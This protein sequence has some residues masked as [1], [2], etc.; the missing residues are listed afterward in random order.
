MKAISSFLRR[1]RE[2]PD[3]R[4]E[5]RRQVLTDELLD[6]PAR[7]ERLRAE[8][9]EEFR[10]V[11]EVI[12]A[13]TERMDRVE[14]QL[15]ENAR[16]IAENSRQ[17]AENSRQIASLTERMDRVEAQLQE[18]ARQIAE[19]S[20]QIASLTERM[21]RVE[22]QL[23]ENARQIAENSRQI[24][25]LTRVVR[26]HTRTLSRHGLF[27]GAAVEVQARNS[28][29]AQAEGRGLRFLRPFRFVAGPDWE[30]DGIAEAEGPGGRVWLFLETKSRVDS[31][32]VQRFARLFRRP[33]VLA[34]LRELGIRG[35]AEAWVFAPTLGWSAEDVARSEG[36]GLIESEA[37][38]LVEALPFELASGE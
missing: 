10:R 37:G 23:Q 11:W 1:L 28:L 9:H 3:F 15:Q 25:Q 31:A 6:L 5:V 14:A 21:D 20:R 8:L 26:N 17:I 35:R 30:I 19:N 7:V 18:N 2:D 22:A 34:A 16:Q 13:L 32:D 4:E 24:D 38:V 12:G 33:D 27:I 29:K 36:V